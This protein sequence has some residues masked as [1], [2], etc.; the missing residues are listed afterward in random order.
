MSTTFEKSARPIEK[1]L[2]SRDD[3]EDFGHEPADVEVV[4]AKTK[5]QEM[6]MD[7]TANTNMVGIN[8]MSE[9]TITE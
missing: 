9:T 7:K 2:A 1:S 8:V 4:L 6:A 3:L 5:D